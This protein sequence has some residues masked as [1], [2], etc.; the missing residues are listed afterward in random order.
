MNPCETSSLNIT[1]STQKDGTI[2]K[3]QWSRE[4]SINY[5][6]FTVWSD[7][8]NSFKESEIISPLV[9]N[10]FGRFLNYIR[11]SLCGQVVF[12]V[13]CTNKRAMV[14]RTLKK[15][16]KTP[17]LSFFKLNRMTLNDILCLYLNTVKYEGSESLR[18]SA[19]KHIQTVMYKN[20]KIKSIP[21]LCIKVPFCHDLKKY[22][23]KCSFKKILDVPQLLPHTIKSNILENLNI[24]N[25]RRENILEILGSGIKF[26]KNFSIEV[27]P[28]CRC[29][30]ESDSH[31]ILLPENFNG[32]VST[33]LSQNCKNIPIPSDI[34]LRSE[35]IIAISDTLTRYEK[36]FSQWEV[37]KLNYD[38]YGKYDPESC[39]VK[40]RFLN[41]EPDFSEVYK[42]I[43]DCIKKSKINSFNCDFSTSLEDV[44]IVK[45]L[46]S[47]FI[48]LPLDKN[49]GKLSVKYF[50]DL[51]DLFYN[52]S[53]HYINV[54]NN[55]TVNEL[56]DGFLASFTENMWDK[57]GVFDQ[58]GTLHYGYAVYKNKDLSR[59][60][61]IVSYYGHPLK[62]V[63]YNTQRA[64][65]FIIKSLDLNHFTLFTTQE[66]A[67]RMD[68]IQKNLEQ[69]YGHE[70]EFL[71]YSYDIKEM[72]SEVPH[73]AVL[74]SIEFLV[75]NC[76]ESIRSKFIS[77]PNDKKLSVRFG[78]ASNIHNTSV[79]HIESLYDIVKYELENAFFTVGKYIFKQKNGVPIGSV[80]SGVES[81]AVCV[82]SEHE[83][84][85]SLGDYKYLIGCVRF[86][87]D[88]SGVIA[89]SKSIQHT[90]YRAKKILQGYKTD[91]Y[92]KEL[93][94][95]EEEIK[96]GSYRFLETITTVN[97]NKINVKHFLKNSDSIKNQGRQKFFNI[98]RSSSYESGQSK[99]GVIISRLITM[100]RNTPNNTDLVEVV[101]EFFKEMYFLGYNKK[102]LKSIC[103][104]MRRKSN[105]VVWDTNP[106]SLLS[107]I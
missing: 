72:Y 51:K 19:L 102:L 30:T 94:L 33:V 40:K 3:I 23:I 64:I 44:K 87:D 1:L 35:L 57:I 101:R 24:V 81:M 104:I 67:K 7:I 27:I 84:I 47:G 12:K 50:H 107:Y 25:T 11:T 85:A 58:N 80:L 4:E 63:F 13:Y 31:S 8:Y 75:H 79:F 69:K 15:I 95:K 99:K 32:I 21:K 68:E 77:V 56:Y 49:S 91:C 53:N 36:L 39:K 90:K 103:Y 66:Y 73:S 28:I 54:T 26:A 34:N 17:R 78:K 60:R 105:R 10:D 92:P 45:R 62:S 89:Y 20:Y 46:L 5:L 6:D 55:I 18:D 65:Y 48:F 82:M 98:K 9:F 106:S 52:D 83:W 38:T 88:C 93:I 43:D 71:C 70:T 42:I 16:V 76:S 74:R 29:N 37:N 61:T 41:N 2:V 96:N 59:L 100:E 86:V 14:R 22:L 97:K